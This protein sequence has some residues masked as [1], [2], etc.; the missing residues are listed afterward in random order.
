MLVSSSKSSALS[1][2]H[3]G[4]YEGQI[5]GWDPKGAWVWHY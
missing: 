5:L 1:A 4:S 3:R 2:C